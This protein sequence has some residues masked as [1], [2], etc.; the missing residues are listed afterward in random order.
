MAD[1][2]P[3][4][5]QSFRVGSLLN[6]LPL[7][8]DAVSTRGQK[9]PSIIRDRSTASIR[10]LRAQFT[11]LQPS[12]NDEDDIE[13]DGGRRGG[14]R[15]NDNSEGQRRRASNGS[16]VLMTPQMRSM[17]LIGNNNLRYQW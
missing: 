7:S 8:D 14:E 11:Q 17:R 16:Q 3:F 15:G 12:N 10:D 4:R 6:F 1:A 13:R 2:Q 9:L 5:P